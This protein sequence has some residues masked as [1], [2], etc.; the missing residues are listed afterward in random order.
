MN[1]F[2]IL[3]IILMII[4]IVIVVIYHN[5]RNKKKS[6]NKK[7]NKSI[8]THSKLG[9]RGDMGN[10]LFQ[11]ATLHS[12]SS[13]KDIRMCI[14]SSVSKLPLYELFPNI[15]KLTQ[16]DIKSPMTE[17]GEFSNY[18]KFDNIKQW[19]QFY[20][21]R[22]YRQNY[23]YF[24]KYGDEIRQLFTPDAILISK[25]K[26]L[27]PTKFNVIHVRLGDYEK[28]DNEFTIIKGFSK[29]KTNYYKNGYDLLTDEHSIVYPTIVCSND[30][31]KATNM[32]K[33]VIPN[34]LPSSNYYE[35][36]S[37]KFADFIIMYLATNIIMCNSTYSW[38]ATY[39]SN[40][41][42]EKVVCP[43]PWWNPKGFIGTALALDGPYLHYPKWITLDPET[44]DLMTKRTDNDKNVNPLFKIGRGV[45]L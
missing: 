8:I 27:L 33:D 12:I 5:I 18:D 6:I 17:L 1:A 11:I 4:F 19:G 32:L 25:I 3:F 41:S 40:N 38:W 24:D 45:V 30:L 16:D 22:G 14:P 13:E 2:V 37:P 42:K 9:K 10:Q 26:K 39:L 29:C 28:P 20:D 15:S 43:S 21:L 34:I 23:N 36:V 35:D 7:K 31:P 44:G